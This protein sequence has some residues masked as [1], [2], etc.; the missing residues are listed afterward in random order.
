MR[1]GE[2]GGEWKNLTVF[3]PHP[4]PHRFLDRP[5]FS[6]RAAASLTLRTTKERKK[7]PPATEAMSALRRES[8][9]Y[10]KEIYNHVHRK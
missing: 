7:K 9:S 8:L 10:G 4:L 2:G 6:F 3:S 5:R 1:K